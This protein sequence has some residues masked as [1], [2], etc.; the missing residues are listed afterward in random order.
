MILTIASPH[1]ASVPTY[2]TNEVAEGTARV[3]FKLLSPPYGI[4]SELHSY[5]VE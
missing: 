4:Y 2:S 5:I 3:L 1:H